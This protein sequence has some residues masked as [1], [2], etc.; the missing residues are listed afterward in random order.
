MEN[1]EKAN[2][3]NGDIDTPGLGRHYCVSCARY[4]ISETAMQ[5]H[6]KTKAH[7]RQLKQLKTEE[8]YLGP[9]VKIDNGMRAP[10]VTAVSIDPSASSTTAAAATPLDRVTDDTDS[11]ID[12]LNRM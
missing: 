12:D 5:S 11:L 8:V 6:E 9:D 1:P 7:K 10:A 3:K 4:F 2:D